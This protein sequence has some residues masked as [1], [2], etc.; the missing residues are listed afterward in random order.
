[1][2]PPQDA[3]TGLDLPVPSEAAGVAA[4]T[5]RP[6]VWS[7]RLSVLGAALSVPGVA[8]LLAPA[9]SAHDLTRILT[10]SAYGLG[11]L[12]MF[13]CSALFH[14]QAGRPRVFT[15]CLDYGAIGVMIAGCFTPYCALALGTPF[16]F[17]ILAFVWALALG[18]AGLRVANPRLSKWIFVAIFLAMGWLGMLLAPALWGAMGRGGSYLTLLG[19]ALYTAGT[20]FFN[21]F[22]GD[23]EPPGFGPHDIWHVVILAAAGAHYL[24]ILLYVAPPR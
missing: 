19:G 15:K 9:I 14:A 3:A 24:A 2:T 4:E 20:L 21:R 5:E 7:T 10:F 1:M 18:A 8:A 23:V 22:E 6:E 13:T 17:R 11:L 12:S 16:A